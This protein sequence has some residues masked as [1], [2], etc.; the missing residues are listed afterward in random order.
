MLLDED[1]RAE[2]STIASDH[3]A[4][5]CDI[6]QC[7]EKGEPDQQELD[8]EMSNVMYEMRYEL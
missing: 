3:W 4:S 1:N 7:G 5:A 6:K 2:F 8:T